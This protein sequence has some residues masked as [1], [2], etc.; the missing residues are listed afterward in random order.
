MSFIYQRLCLLLITLI[1]SSTSLYAQ[2]VFNVRDFGAKG[3]GKS[4]D[5]DALSRVA[6]LINKQ[7]G[8]VLYFPAGDYYI[9]AYHHNNKINDIEFK[10]GDGLKIY[11]KNAKISVKGN[12]HRTVTRN[13]RYVRSTITAIIPLKIT[14]Y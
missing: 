12:F 2:T 4:N 6:K 13:D 14:N 11:G 3:D 10:N 9:D 5:Y 7:G 1:I 8:G